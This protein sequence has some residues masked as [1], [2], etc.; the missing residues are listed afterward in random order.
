MSDEITYEGGCLCGAVRFK[1]RGAPERT[2]LCHC[3]DCRRTSGSAFNFFAVWP[4][5]AYAGTGELASFTERSFCPKCGS[6]IGWIA[7]EG[8]EIALGA[9][10]QAPSDLAPDYEL[11]VLRREEWML[12]LPWAKQH[13]QDRD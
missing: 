3:L 8:V 6:R 7:D 9:L 1:L 4:R 13:K 12:S 2:G 5:S 10:D 11:W